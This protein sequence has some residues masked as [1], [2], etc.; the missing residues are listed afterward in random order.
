MA[1][2]SPWERAAHV[3]LTDATGD[4]WSATRALGQ[5]ELVLLPR[6]IGFLAQP[7]AE[8]AIKAVLAYARAPEIP[9][10]HDIA[11]LLARIPA[12]PVRPWTVGVRYPRVGALTAM[13]VQGRYAVLGREVDRA[14]A[15][16]LTA[17]ATGIYRACLHDLVAHGMQV[18]GLAIP[19]LLWRP[20]PDRCPGGPAR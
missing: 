15:A 7:G 9:D 17:L 18:Q 4:L 1:N 3:W 5:T 8:K 11:M 13:A 20:D 16:S 14:E 6:Q 12:D 10:R 2:P 19:A